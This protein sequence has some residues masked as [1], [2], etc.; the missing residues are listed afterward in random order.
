MIQI[1]KLKRK[2]EKTEEKLFDLEDNRKVEDRNARNKLKI[3]V[4]IN[5]YN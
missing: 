5:R 4:N 1:C 2:G 3:I